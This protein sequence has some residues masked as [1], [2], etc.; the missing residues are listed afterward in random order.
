MGMVGRNDERAPEV[1][2]IK[3]QQWALPLLQAWR[4]NCSQIIQRKAT[5]EQGL[6]NALGDVV[7][8]FPQAHNAYAKPGPPP[9]ASKAHALDV[10]KTQ[11]RS[12]AGF[13][14]EIQPQ[15]HEAK[16]SLHDG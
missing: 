9:R 2:A 1:S 8:G 14:R 5:Q 12:S 3:Q 6:Y 11:P 15:H 16:E 13:D 10:N 4:G 7:A